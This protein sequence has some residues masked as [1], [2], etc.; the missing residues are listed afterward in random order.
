LKTI[1]AFEVKAVASA[2][3]Y[4]K[5]TQASLVDLSETITNIDQARPVTQLTVDDIVKANP[6]V[7]KRT[8][9]MVKKGQFTVEGYDEKFP[10]L[11]LL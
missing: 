4:V 3:Q 2:E 8:E 10:S 9:E 5:E 11:A 1:S 7:V 6:E